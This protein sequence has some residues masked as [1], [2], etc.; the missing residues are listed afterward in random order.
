MQNIPPI[1]WASHHPRLAAWIVLSLG[2]IG[3]I[4]FEGRNVGLLA[5]QWAALWVACVMV[6]GLCIW[7]ISW[8]DESDTLVETTSTTETTVEESAV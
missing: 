2:M 4:T 3:L 5:R 8:E 1:N 6:A 7:I